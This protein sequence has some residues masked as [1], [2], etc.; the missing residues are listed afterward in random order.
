MR[1]RNC[2]T[3]LMDTDL[4]CPSCHSSRARAT[5]RPPGENTKPSYWWIY[6]L[7]AFGG[8]IGGVIAGLI[9]AGS[10]RS[11]ETGY[12]TAAPAA[13]GSSP[14]KTM[15]GLFFILGG[16]LLFV[17]ASFMFYN[18]WKIAQWVPKEVTA[19]ELRQTKDPASYPDPWIAYTFEASKPAQMNV[20]RQRMNHG[21][22]VVARGL[23]VPVED[24]WMFVSVAPGFEGDRLVGRLFPLDPDL[25]KLLVKRLPKLELS[26]SALLPYEF[27]AVDGCKSDWQ[28]RYIGVAV[29]VFLGMVGLFPGLTLWRKRRTA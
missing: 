23:L 21:G 6:L 25:S 8:A 19:A 29:C 22:E 27:H 26:P 11:D 18:T 13:G 15:I 16:L 7:P 1:C 14:V 3:Q 4:A 12:S 28:Q 5:S 24:K 17:N 9:I 2:H 20:R 10:A